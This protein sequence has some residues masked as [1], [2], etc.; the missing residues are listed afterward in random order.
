MN[1][2]DRREKREERREERREK[3]GEKREER[4]EK[5]EEKREQPRSPSRRQNWTVYYATQAMLS[6]LCMY[7]PLGCASSVC[8]SFLR[9]F[10]CSFTFLLRAFLFAFFPGWVFLRCAFACF[11]SARTVS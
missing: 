7:V 9:S 1:K 5:R 6:L 8:L 11:P 4:R 2:E 10:L 3:R